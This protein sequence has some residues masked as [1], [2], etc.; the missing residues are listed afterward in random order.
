MV[1]MLLEAGEPM[2][3]RVDAQGLPFARPGSQMV[4][5]VVDQWVFIA[6]WVFVSRETATLC[7]M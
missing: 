2:R 4:P 7:L 1:V 3:M 5:L 6:T